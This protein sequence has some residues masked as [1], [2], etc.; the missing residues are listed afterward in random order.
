MPII[1]EFEDFTSHYIAEKNQVIYTRLAAD[2]D[3]PVSLMMKLTGTQKDSF[4][5]ESVTGGEV[6]GRY[7]VVGMKPDLVWKCEGNKSYLNRDARFDQDGYVLQSKA[8]SQCLIY[9]RKLPVVRVRIQ[10][11]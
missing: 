7:S 9:Q 10:L 1:S 2:L 11:C 3:T 8:P 5:L 6:R 4:V